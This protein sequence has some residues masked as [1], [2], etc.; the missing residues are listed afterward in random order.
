MQTEKAVRVALPFFHK[1]TSKKAEVVGASPLQQTEFEAA[2]FGEAF[3]TSDEGVAGVAG[4]RFG[5]VVRHIAPVVGAED[6]FRAAV[7][8]A[9]LLYGEKLFDDVAHWN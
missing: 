9:L 1:P 4:G 5:E 7:V 2:E 3:H 8:D 6:D